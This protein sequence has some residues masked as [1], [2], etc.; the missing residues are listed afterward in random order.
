VATL[1][2]VIEYEKVT[3]EIVYINLPGPEEPAP[4]MSGPELLHGFLADIYRTENPEVKSHIN[5][6]CNRWN[7][8]YREKK[9]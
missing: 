4:G 8:H 6:I 7:V 1:G 3:T 5:L 9:N 2:Q